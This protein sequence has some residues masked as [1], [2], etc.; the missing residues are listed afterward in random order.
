MNKWLRIIWKIWYFVFPLGYWLF[1]ENGSSPPSSAFS[2]ECWTWTGAAAKTSNRTE[3]AR[4]TPKS[5]C[6][7]SRERPTF[8]RKRFPETHPKNSCCRCWVLLFRGKRTSQRFSD[9]RRS[10]RSFLSSKRFTQK[11]FRKSVPL[12]FSERFEGMFRESEVIWIFIRLHKRRTLR[13]EKLY[14]QRFPKPMPLEW[15]SVSSPLR[16]MSSSCVHPGF[17]SEWK[18][19]APEV[20]HLNRYSLLSSGCFRL[21]ILLNADS[22]ISMSPLNAK[23]LTPVCAEMGNPNSLRRSRIRGH[24]SGSNKRRSFR[25]ASTSP[26]KRVRTRAEKYR[27]CLIYQPFTVKR[28]KVV[29]FG[30]GNVLGTL[31]T[32]F[33]VSEEEGVQRGHFAFGQKF[34]T[35]IAEVDEIWMKQSLQNSILMSF[36]QF[37]SVNNLKEFGSK[38]TLNKFILIK[39]GLCFENKSSKHFC[40]SFSSSKFSTTRVYGSLSSNVSTWVANCAELLRL[41]FQQPLAF[42]LMWFIEWQI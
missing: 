30:F 25:V 20:G 9:V 14:W 41:E 19:S 32:H 31:L 5:R 36:C 29:A 17:S 35:L 16:V 37:F 3:T 6:R 7:P 13:L 28:S 34:D 11:Q 15:R 21:S 1:S 23:Y 39:L 22:E 38:L 27:L 18:S 40:D 2:L 12:R 42:T 4:R 10:N 8:A 33:A 24:F 26:R